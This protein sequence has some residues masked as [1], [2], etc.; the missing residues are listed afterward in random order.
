MF[1]RCCSAGNVYRHAQA[2]HCAMKKKHPTPIFLQ[3][4]KHCNEMVWDFFT[5]VYM[6]RLDPLYSAAPQSS[7]SYWRVYSS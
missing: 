2:G 6:R 4:F 3:N 5:S 7:S 1:I